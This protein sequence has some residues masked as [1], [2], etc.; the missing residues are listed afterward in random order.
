MYLNATLMLLF[1][2]LIFEAKGTSLKIKD[3]C[4]FTSSIQSCKYFVLQSFKCSL[5]Y[6]RE[7][8]GNGLFHTWPLLS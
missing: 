7:T 2:K 4:L 6:R 8:N 1:L 5:E 3:T